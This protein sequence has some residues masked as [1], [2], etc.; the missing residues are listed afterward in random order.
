MSERQPTFLSGQDW[1]PVILKKR[2]DDRKMAHAATAG[3]RA[4]GVHFSQ[5]AERLRKIENAE[6][7]VKQKRLAPE[8]K[9]QIVNQRVANSWSQADLN[10]RCSFPPN[11]IR[12]IE[13]GKIVPNGQMLNVLNRVLKVSLRLI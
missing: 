9:Q 13:A 8:S 3:Q 10:M 4:A 6:G 1:D 2:N 7:P 11:T 12:D 5:E